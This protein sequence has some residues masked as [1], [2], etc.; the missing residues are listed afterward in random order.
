MKVLIVSDQEFLREQMRKAAS[1]F[2]LEISEADNPPSAIAE[3]DSGTYD[4]VLSDTFDTI[5]PKFVIQAA[6]RTNPQ[7]R[8]II[9]TGRMTIWMLIK[10]LILGAFDYVDFHAPYPPFKS[11]LRR[12]IGSAIRDINSKENFNG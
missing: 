8:V 12:A 11:A 3:L 5:Q 9:V 10:T 4:I 1:S 2:A 6:L 7:I